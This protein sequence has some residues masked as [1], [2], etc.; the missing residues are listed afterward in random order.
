MSIRRLTQLSDSNSFFLFGARG[1]GKTTLLK[2][3][4]FL[5][6][7]IYIDLLDDEM[8]ERYSL[9]PKLLIE[10]AEAMSEGKWIIIDEIQKAPKLLDHVHI[11]IEKKGIRFASQELGW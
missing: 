4:P 10:Q 6:D 9:R 5:K 1:T 2:E 11:L 3:L 7:A 8:E